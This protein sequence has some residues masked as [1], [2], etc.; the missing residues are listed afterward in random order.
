LPL[1]GPVPEGVKFFCPTCGALYSAT[2]T[3]AGKNE[4]NTAKCVVCL[5]FMDQSDSSALP[6]YKLILRPEM[7]EKSKPKLRVG[8]RCKKRNAFINDLRCGETAICG[9]QI[10]TSNVLKCLAVVDTSLVIIDVIQY[11]D[12][13][14]LVP[15][16]LDSD[17]LWCRPRRMVY[18][19]KLRHYNFRGLGAE[20]ADFALDETLSEDVLNCRSGI[21]KGLEHQI[22]DLPALRVRK[23]QPH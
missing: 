18:A 9:E 5:R 22:I 12:K 15:E 17:G 2:R 7:L 14:W 19:G 11:R 21:P 8:M 23:P 4:T 3:Q 6:E 16:W 10:I 20:A 13:F 1:T